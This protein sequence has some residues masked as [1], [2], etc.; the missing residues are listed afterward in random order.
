[1]PRGYQVLITGGLEKNGGV[2]F[3]Q[4]NRHLEAGERN[5]EYCFKHNERKEKKE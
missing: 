5:G 1:M 4:D 2:F 3:K